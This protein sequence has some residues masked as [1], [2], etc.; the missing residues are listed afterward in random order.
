VLK[1]IVVTE[2]F[3][4]RKK[5]WSKKNIRAEKEHAKQ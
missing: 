1:D 2:V 5:R 3:K 4:K